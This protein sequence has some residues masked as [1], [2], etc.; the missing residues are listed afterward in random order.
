MDP[1]TDRRKSGVYRHRMVKTSSEPVSVGEAIRQAMDGL[2]ITEKL[3]EQRV[4]SLW[5]EIVGEEIAVTTVDDL[6]WGQLFVSVENATHR[7]WLSF[8]RET[9][10][11][12][13]NRAV[14]GEVVQMIRFQ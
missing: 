12:N 6:R 1:E 2:G 10:C 9:I 13:L 5:P 8:Q 11:E 14:G 3:R 4:I 7:H